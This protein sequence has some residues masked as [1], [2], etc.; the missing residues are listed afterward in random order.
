VKKINNADANTAP[1]VVVAAGSTMAITYDV[2]NTGNVALSGVKVTDDKVAA[3]SISCPKASLAI[4]E[5]MQCTAALAAPAPGVQHT[6]T[7]TV[8]G[9]SPQNVTV[10][11]NDPANAT[12]VATPS[13]LL[14]KKI[15]GDDANVAP[16]VE[17]EGGSTMK[18]TYLVKNEG[19]V[20]LTD[21][22][23]TDD[24]IAA[25]DID[26][27]K[28]TLSVG[29]SMTCTASHAA[30]GAGRPHHNMG[31]VEGT[32]VTGGEKV[33]DEDPANA[34][35]VPAPSISIVKSING[36]DANE[37]PGVKVEAGST[38]KITYL[39]TNTGNIGLRDV[40][41]TD[42]KVPADSITCPKDNLYIGEAMT[43]TASLAAPAVGV[44]HTNT[45]TVVAQP[46]N[47]DFIPVG[48][49]VTD[50]DPAN[51]HVVPAPSI[52]IVKSIN[53]DD[54]NEAPGVT[55]K[56]G[57]QMT[58]TFEVSNTGNVALSSVAVTDDTIKASA[59]DCPKAELKVGETMVC[60]AKLL[61]PAAGTTHTN[62]GTAT[63]TDPF[64]AKV[65]DTDPANATTPADP[66]VTPEPKGTQTGD[67]L[68]A[69][70]GTLLAGGLVLMLLAVA[71]GVMVIRRVR[72]REQ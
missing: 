13:I 51:A 16:G 37:A 17:V 57:D 69:R 43:C 46:T 62:T 41:V 30:P 63:A 33:T 12:V 59:I 28:D 71:M 49:K 6:N 47:D 66:V 61:A 60:T 19:N 53:G 18:I 7:G 1:G 32:P 42:D 15:N 26:C 72:T 9:T 4:G 11:A 58:V 36:D 29:E 34:H 38:M 45:G 10:N 22:T 14:V 52:S 24:K 25:E 65:T 3:A 23:V 31:S 67:R 48:E 64:G 2:K 20:D 56:K 40:V 5:T 44:Q 70:D 27:P 35:V 39:V 54:A 8:V 50:N 21:V 68:M 55:V